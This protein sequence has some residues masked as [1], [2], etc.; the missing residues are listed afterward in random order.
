VT[1]ELVPR[2]DEADFWDDADDGPKYKVRAGRYRFPDPPGYVRTKGQAPGFM[3]MTNLAG[4]FSDQKRLQAWRE[5]MLLLGLR[6]D[7]AIFDE[8]T[9]APLETMDAGQAKAFLEEM[10]DKAVQAAG[11]D[12]GARRGTARHIMLQT[13]LETGVLTGT[14]TMR[15]QLESLF[16]ALRRHHLKPIPGWSE[17]RVCNPKFHVIGTLDMAV[18]CQLTGQRGILDLKTQRQF[19]SYLEICGQQDGYDGAPWVWE[20]PE[21][22]RGGWVEAPTWDLLGQPG[23]VAPGRRVAL[24]AHMPAAPG[25]NVLPV[26]IHEVDLEFG[27]RVL[28]TALQNVQMRSLGNSKAAGRRVGGV[29]PVPRIRATVDLASSAIAD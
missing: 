23:G 1:T 15:L 27:E 5:R 6:L 4:A 29:R 20:G 21:D 12:R 7:E 22:E 25:P 28:E 11:G 19:W 18:E 26:E 14:R 13:A 8:V 24:L 10:A 2:G 17:R 9:A 16:D 3:R